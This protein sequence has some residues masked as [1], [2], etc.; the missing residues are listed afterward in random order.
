MAESMSFLAL[1]LAPI[2]AKLIFRLISAKRTGMS[3]FIAV[4]LNLSL[5]F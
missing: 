2:L 4:L 3:L 1:L 5:T